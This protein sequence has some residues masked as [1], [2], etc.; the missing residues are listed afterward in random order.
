MKAVLLLLPFFLSYFLPQGQEEVIHEIRFQ[1]YSRGYQK[2]IILRPDS[3]FYHENNPKTGDIEANRETVP[4]EWKQLTE[5]VSGLSL[6]DIDKLESPT[7]NRA[8]DKALHS[9]ITIKTSKGEYKS[10]TFD[11]YNPHKKLSPLV[12][13]I[14]EIENKTRPSDSN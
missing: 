10:S 4:A 7:N 8:S 2:T 5:A 13:Q 14:R 3:V 12:E 9:N 11:G 1:S 6:D